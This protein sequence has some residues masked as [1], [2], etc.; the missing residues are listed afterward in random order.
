MFARLIP[1]ITLP[2]IGGIVCLMLGSCQPEEFVFEDNPIPFYDEVPTVLVQNYINR[3]FIDLIGRE[4]NDAEM[5]ANV[6]I[7]EAGVLAA[8]VRLQVVNE[9]IQGSD[10]IDGSTYA[11]MYHQKLYS[12][13]KARF[14]EGASDALLIDRYNQIRSAAI[15]DSLGGNFA[16]YALK[17]AAANRMLLVLACRTE[18]ESGTIDVRT[19]CERMIW[20]GIYDQINMNSF[21]FIHASFDD[22]Y[23]RFPTESEFDAAYLAIEFNSPAVL[24][25]RAVQDK[26]SYLD[27]MLLNAEW[28]EGMVRWVYRGLLARDPSDGEVLE[29]VD[30]FEFELL[31]PEIQRPVLISDEYA[32][33]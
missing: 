11:G 17:Q 31:V 24:F 3:Y 25:G 26:P 7:L 10:S 19:V 12:D 23:Q 16:G 28:N 21:N 5:A 18:L 15:N 6:E 29:G 2:L 13:L 32:G 9:L 27:A 14:I 30:V 4:P 33:F 22:L 8:E 20:N 1:T